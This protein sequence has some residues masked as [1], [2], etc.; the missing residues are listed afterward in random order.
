[1]DEALDAGLIDYVAS[2]E[3]ELMTLLDGKAI[4]RVD[5]SET[6]VR[7]AGQPIVLKEMTTKERI[8][9]VIANPNLAVLLGLIGLAGLYLEFSNPGMILPGVVGA[10]SLLLA[11]FAFEILPVNVV[12]ILLLLVGFGLL[13]AEAL[14]PSFGVLGAGGI[15]GIVLGAFFLF[16]QQPLP[17]PALR[18]S[19][20]VILPVAIFFSAL[21]VAVGRMVFKAQGHRV[22]TGS[23]GL[24][25]R[26]ATARTPIDGRGKVF[27]HGEYWDARSKERIEEGEDV[28]VVGIEG[29]L[30]EVERLAK[31]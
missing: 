9:S 6:V 13:V 12:G 3:Q 1:V 18:V 23:E 7:T 22:Q 17:T 15:V 20:G 28:R 14:T 27:V 31:S 11:A 2:S 10:I 24:I 21:V 5:G 30:L 26:V 8:L 25:G 19:W 4:R 16:E 29:L